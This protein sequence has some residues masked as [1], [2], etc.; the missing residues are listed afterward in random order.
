M[1]EF[2]E[3]GRLAKRPVFAGAMFGVRYLRKADNSRAMTAKE[4]FINTVIIFS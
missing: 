2:K 4:C 3:A 1:F